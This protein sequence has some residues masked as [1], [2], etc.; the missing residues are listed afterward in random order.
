MQHPAIEAV[1][2][3]AENCR[4]LLASD[5]AYEPHHDAGHH[6]SDYL[7]GDPGEA[8]AHFTETA[9]AL[10]LANDPTHADNATALVADLRP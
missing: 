10:A 5:G 7:T 9:V 3:P 1:T 4:L 6:L 2:V 8:A